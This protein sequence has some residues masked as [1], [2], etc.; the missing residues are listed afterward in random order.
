MLYLW[1]W[2]GLTPIIRIAI[3][4]WLSSTTERDTLM[5]QRSTQQH[6]SP[7][8]KRYSPHT[9]LEQSCELTADHHLIPESLQV[10]TEGFQIARPQVRDSSS[11][12][13]SEHRSTSPLAATGAKPYEALMDRI[14]NSQVRLSNKRVATRRHT[15]SDNGKIFN[16]LGW[17]DEPN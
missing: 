3:T 7:S 2:E 14:Q 8:L 6:F 1:I 10:K 9:E 12:M 17:Q 4:T 11:E 13:L 16:Y 15:S 5:L